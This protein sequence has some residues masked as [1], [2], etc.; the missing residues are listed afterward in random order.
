MTPVGEV[1]DLVEST[2]GVGASHAL[3]LGEGDS[4]R[5]LALGLRPLSV[6]WRERLGWV[7]ENVVGICGDIEPGK[8]DRIL[9]G[10]CIHRSCGEALALPASMLWEMLS[11]AMVA[12]RLGVP[13]VILPP[14]AEEAFRSPELAPRY[15]EMG[16]VLNDVIPKLGAELGVDLTCQW[17]G[18]L[19]RDPGID[20]SELYGLFHPFSKSAALRFYPFGR[21][22]ESAVLEVHESYCARYRAV[23]P[24]LSQF[25]LLCE[26]VYVSRSVQLGSAGTGAAYLAT[27]PVPSIQGHRLPMTD[28]IEA[29]PVRR[30]LVVP[31][32]WWPDR[33][34]INVFDS[35]FDEVR[36]LFVRYVEDVTSCSG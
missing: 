2:W 23:R 1:E 27:V 5:W 36:E 3:T 18:E 8:I 20:R 31:T 21:P 25:D 32:G 26:A 7:E 13:G 30:A 10:V 28:D 15:F 24:E 35:T 16:R 22:D 4:E 6:A 33:L 11:I 14:V 17:R 12:G 34:L 29:L 9:G 19:S